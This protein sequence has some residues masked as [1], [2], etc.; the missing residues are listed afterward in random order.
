M[1]EGLFD[2][3]KYGNLKRLQV[4]I[5]SENVNANINEG[6]SWTPLQLVSSYGNYHCIPFLLSLGAKVD[7]IDECSRTP[8]F[9]AAS[10]LFGSSDSNDKLQCVKLLTQ[11]WPRRNG[12][13][14]ITHEMVCPL[15]EC[16]EFGR[17]ETVVELTASGWPI[18]N[19]SRFTNPKPDKHIWFRKFYAQVSNVKNSMTA[20]ICMTRSTSTCKLKGIIGKDMIHLI[21]KEMWKQ[22][23]TI[24]V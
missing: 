19:Y 5:T 6:T 3:L 9:Y 24:N 17:S 23:V 15:K 7:Q 10:C 11:S 1:E 13:P 12:M 18:E 8:L 22:G 14:I 4:F 2:L 21:V 20:W 16:I